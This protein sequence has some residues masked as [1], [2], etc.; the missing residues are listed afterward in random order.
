[1]KKFNSISP[2]IMLL[3]PM[4]LIIGLLMFNMDNEI[5][6]EKYKASLKLQVPSF[7]VMLSNIF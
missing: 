2:F 4:I 5:S 1:M 7:K 3:T 6:A